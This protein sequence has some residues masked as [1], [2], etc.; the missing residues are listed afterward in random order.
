[1]SKDLVPND[2]MPKDLADEQ[3]SFDLHLRARNVARV[4]FASWYFAAVMFALIVAEVLVAVLWSADMIL[5]KT[6][7]ALYFAGLA[8]ACRGA[9]AKAWPTQALPLLFGGGATLTGLLLS[10][11]LAPHFG[12]T[13]A[14][15]TTVFV[16]CLAPLWTRGALLSLLIPVHCLYL[17][18]VFAGPHD[19]IF[20]TVM[21][22][23]GTAVLPLGV[24]TAMLAL[25]SE[26][27][28]F[29]DMAAIRNL[30]AERRD[31]VA[32]VAHDLQSPLAGIRALL[33]TISAHPEAAKLAEIERA[34]RDMYGA[35]SRL[36]EAHRHDG[37]ERPNLT[38]VPVDA[39]FAEAKA[40][41]AAVAAAKQIAIVAESSDVSVSADPG[42]LGAIVDN[43]VS[44]AIKYS[45]AGS[46]VRLS[47]EARETEIRLCVADSGPG[48]ASDEVSLLFKKFS[49]LGTPP[50][51]GEETTGLG[52]YIVRVFAERIGARAGF[53][54]N[55]AGGSIFF[56]DVAR[57][58]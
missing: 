27:Q 39:L 29:E 4:Q 21:T 31:M 28:A 56:V 44:N 37:V 6:F 20:R 51:A 13:P 5:L 40:K 48:I 43:L 35:V 33:R 26:R 7:S 58:P 53:A 36:V 55:P 2:W 47:A 19:V 34:C 17:W 42:L 18:T 49:R 46:A 10:R 50:T 15:A 12:A 14:Y 45:P 22:V 52:L 38:A 1:M 30:L 3:P 32:M 25:R 16:A 24:A 54:P 8:L 11:D 41:A 57:A 23:G 9:H